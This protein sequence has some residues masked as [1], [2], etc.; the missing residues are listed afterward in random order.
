MKLKPETVGF[1]RG[2]DLYLEP[3]AKWRSWQ[4]DVWTCCGA[5]ERRSGI[6]QCRTCHST[7][8][9]AGGAPNFCPRCRSR[10][11]VRISDA[12]TARNAT[13]IVADELHSLDR[14]PAQ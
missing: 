14:N 10:R 9:F 5:G 1:V 7:T 3:P 12:M 11:L 8:L 6:W 2:G 4:R 13:L